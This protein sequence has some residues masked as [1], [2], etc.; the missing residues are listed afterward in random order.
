MG[1]KHVDLKAI[2]NASDQRHVDLEAI[3]NVFDQRH[4]DL[5]AISNVFDKNEIWDI[6]TEILNLQCLNNSQMTKAVVL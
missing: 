1:Q 3:S 4:V 6:G 2:S 5:E